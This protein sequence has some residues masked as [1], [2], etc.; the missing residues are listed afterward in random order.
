MNILIITGYSISHIYPLESLILFLK[1]KYNISIICTQKNEWLPKKWNI[2]TIVYPKK[3]WQCKYKDE[4][5]NYDQLIKNYSDIKQQYLCYLEKDILTTLNHFE[6]VEIF[7]KNVMNTANPDIVIKDSTDIYWDIIKENY[8]DVKTIG[9]ITNNLYSWNYLHDRNNLIHFLGIVDIEKQLGDTFIENFENILKNIYTKIVNQKKEIVPRLYYQYDPNERVN[10]IFSMPFFQPIQSLNKM[11]KNFII[12]PELENFKT[13]SNI[14]LDLINFIDN[15]KIIYISTGSFITKNIEYYI[16]LIQFLSSKCKNKIIISA[17]KQAEY[18][19]KYVKD[20]SPDKKVYISSYIPQKYVL[21]Q[22]CLFISTGG[23]NS[24]KEAIYFKVPMLII[25]ITCEQR[26]N[27]LIIE[28]LGIGY[29]LYKKSQEK[30]DKIINIIL[31]KNENILKNLDKYS[32]L[33]IESEHNLNCFKEIDKWI[34]NE[35]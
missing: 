35:K 15:K 14:P 23:F 34:T 19:Q 31:N 10:I 21:S 20:S 9:F 28:D 24:I 17:G 33:I 7:L 18:L 26:L 25:P 16:K 6:E 4:L 1:K 29:T 12:T 22:S 13:E 8:P 32:S 5:I 30:L 11:N 27:G 2:N 3:Y